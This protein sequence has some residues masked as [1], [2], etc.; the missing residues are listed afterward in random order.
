MKQRPL[1][2]GNWKMNGTLAESVLLTRGLLAEFVSMSATTT[3]P[4]VDVVIAPPFTALAVVAEQLNLIQIT[5]VHLPPRNTA[6]KASSPRGLQLSVELGAQTMSPHEGGAFT[7][8]ISPLMLQELGVRWVIL[9]HSERRARCGESD[10]S[11]ARAVR[12]ALA[13]HLTPIVAVGESAAEHEAGLAHARVTAQTL[14]AL[15]ELD[16]KA[17]ARCVIAYEP[18][19]AI[20]AGEGDDPAHANAIMRVIRNSREGLE[21]ARLLYGG[22]VTDENAAGYFSQPNIDGALVGGASLKLGSFAGIVAAADAA[23]RVAQRL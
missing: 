3:H 5:D 12:L 23:R 7:G 16:A 20:G 21:E 1:V 15:A 19:W 2:V 14:A 10:A 18:I 6:A 22:S 11:V 4:A 13:H 9:G 17:V 8:E